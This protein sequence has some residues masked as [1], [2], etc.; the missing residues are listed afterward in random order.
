MVL[1]VD[2]HETVRHEG[3]LAPPAQA[4]VER[5]DRAAD[6]PQVRRVFKLA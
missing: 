2:T 6:V 3:D 1:H 5:G 4:R